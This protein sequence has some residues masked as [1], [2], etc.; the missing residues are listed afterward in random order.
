[1]AMH[2]E[3]TVEGEKRLSRKLHGVE[4]G[5][6]NFYPTFRK[7]GRNLKKTF[8]NNFAYRGRLL[9]KPWESLAMST[10]KEKKRLGYLWQGPLVRTGKMKRSFR[11]RPER[12][13]VTVDNPT[14][15]F[16]YHQS[17][18]PRRHLPR[19]VMISLTKGKRQEIVRMF[20][21][22]VESLLKGRNMGLGY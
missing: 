5:M 7:V 1:M 19:R 22:A 21:K 17:K 10:L 20:Q 18:R 11:S 4:E 2:L 15:Y 3:F 14:P 9:N 6:K 13:Q 8:K 16:K 12:L